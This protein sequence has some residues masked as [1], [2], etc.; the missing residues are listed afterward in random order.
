MSTTTNT[1]IQTSATSSSKAEKK[2]ELKTTVKIS[3]S[4]SKSGY[5]MTVTIA[6]CTRT[7]MGK[8]IPIMNREY[9]P[10]VGSC[11][12]I[13]WSETEENM[14]MPFATGKFTAESRYEEPLEQLAKLLV[15][16][17]TSFDEE[18]RVNQSQRALIHAQRQLEHQQRQQEYEQRRLLLQQRQ[19]RYEQE[20][21]LRELDRQ[22]YLKRQERRANSAAEKARRNAEYERRKLEQEELAPYI[23]SG[24]ERYTIA[25]VGFLKI[26]PGA[27]RKDREFRP[28][29]ASIK[30]E[31]EDEEVEDF[32][33][34][35]TNPVRRRLNFQETTSVAAVAST[36]SIHESSAW[37]DE[38]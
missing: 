18:V 19:Q 13:V 2:V 28:S 17:L 8:I 29:L 35:S 10:T 11:S 37:D 25:D 12:M 22:D 5:T 34:L 33:A 9:R 38:N 23:R 27:P 30:E 20:Q 1:K 32:P 26:A 7:A 31:D 14:K 24:N 3:K 4:K 21:E 6:G 16:A 36:A 15:K